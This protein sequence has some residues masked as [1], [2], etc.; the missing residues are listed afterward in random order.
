MSV[1]DIVYADQIQAGDYVEFIATDYDGEECEPYTEVMT[2]KTVVD[3]TETIQVEGYSEVWG[4]NIYHNVPLARG[5]GLL[6]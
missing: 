2:V 6:A 3:N 5:F 4:E 1:I